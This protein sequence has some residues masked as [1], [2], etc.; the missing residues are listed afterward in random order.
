MPH[1]GSDR[2]AHRGQTYTSLMSRDPGN[3]VRLRVSVE[4]L[5]SY[6]GQQAYSQY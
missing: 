5:D 1:R 2:I 6:N 4:P 3:R